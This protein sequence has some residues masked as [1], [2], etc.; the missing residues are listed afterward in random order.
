[1]KFQGLL[2][3]LLGTALVSHAQIFSA[4]SP[5]LHW[6]KLTS[7]EVNILFPKELKQKAEQVYQQIKRFYDTDSSLGLNRFK[8]NLVLQ[9]QTVLSNGYVGIGP[10]ISEFFL[11]PP[12][13]SY[14]LG[15]VDWTE[16]LTIHEYRHVLQAMNSR[17]GIAQWLYWIL[18]EEA[19]GAA[20]GLAV[21]DWFLEGD[22]VAAETRNTLGGRG[23]MPSFAA[24]YR[25][26]FQSNIQW[27]YIKT[28][29]GSLKDIVPNEYTTG[30]TMVNYINEHFKADTWGKVFDD[31]I[32]YK[33]LFYPFA[34][35][36]YRH[37]GLTP[38]SLYHQAIAVYDTPQAASDS[39]QRY[40]SHSS[41]KVINHMGPNRLKD[42]DI[43][44][45]ETGFDRLP[46]LVR[47]NQEKTVQ[48]YS[49]MGITT[50]E[51]FGF[52]EPLITW[53][54]M[55]LDP[56]WELKN[57]SDIF[58]YNVHTLEKKRLTNQQKFLYSSP[59][60]DGSKIIGVEYLPGGQ[61]NLV[62]LDTLGTT[63]KTILMAQ[64][65]LATFATFENGDT[66]VLVAVRGSAVVS[67]ERFFLSTGSSTTI[68]PPVAAIISNLTVN[69]HDTIF[70]SSD[71]SG[72]DNLFAFD[73]ITKQVYQ[74]TDD[75]VGIQQF[76]VYG[77]EIL[78]NVQ[79]AYG[80]KIKEMLIDTIRFKS[81]NYFTGSFPINT[82]RKL[83]EPQSGLFQF[84]HAGLWSNPFRVYSW[85]LRPD[86]GGNVLRV[87]GRNMLN[88]IQS[89]VA[90]QFLQD[91]GSQ[92]VSG[93]LALG[94][95]YPVVSGSIGHTWNRRI[96]NPNHPETDS[97]RWNETSYRIG[98]YIPLKWYHH[99]Q[100]FQ[101]QP[102]IQL[103]Q[104]LPDYR[105]G[106]RFNYQRTTFLRTGFTLFS[107][108]RRALQHV[109]PRWMQEVNL[110]WNKA[111][112]HKATA[113]ELR[114]EWHFP[115]WSRNHV[116]EL[117]ADYHRQLRT[118]PYRFPSNNEFISGYSAF[119][120]DHSSRWRV[121]YHFPCFY[122]D[123]GINGLIYVK[124]VRARLFHEQMNSTIKRTSDK[125]QVHYASSGLEGLVDGNALNVQPVSF[126]LRF[127]YLWDTDL[128]RNS[129]RPRL[130]FLVEQLF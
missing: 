44:C 52:N 122:P 129:R 68:T 103:G 125:F 79:T 30:F 54:E 93:S 66:T 123:R 120:S 11:T 63:L 7:E 43:V 47:L 9:N 62:I 121:A 42:G 31:A 127:S 90:Y 115:G 23:R 119:T 19:W 101:V 106:D 48:T 71:V 15:S 12:F 130:E 105:T 74:L 26:L 5:G 28:R 18:G 98:T 97:I 22:A 112:N 82:R 77:N 114:S 64:D 69:N 100:I 87:L 118:D 4:H 111:L 8:L 10:F 59:S 124:R 108:Q 113:L 53:T 95:I 84:K 6:S 70:F 37:T 3:L 14:V 33:G 58:T 91:E 72:R 96:S 89:S 67:I 34:R 13:D 78:Y 32:R 16:A 17:K 83:P 51:D 99:N 126:G 49:T 39:T 46:R 24:E 45:L 2:L 94:F 38:K 86:E 76:S 80:V 41:Q 104:Y 50:D 21:P 40:R 109:S 75:P 116:I 56:R 57:Y 1:M 27:P 36:L 102:V 20:Y 128:I 88:T 65:Q 61:C 29:N 35:A 81:I 73:P 110:F 60:N 92:T 85:S 25:A 117:N 55:T 107:Y